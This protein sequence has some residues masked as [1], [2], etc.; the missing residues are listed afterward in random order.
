M[1]NLSSLFTALIGDSFWA[2]FLKV[3]IVPLGVSVV[4]GWA[5]ASV[6]EPRWVAPGW[7]YYHGYGKNVEVL[8]ILGGARR[9]YRDSPACPL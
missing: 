3:F 9:W 2:R 1:R 7:P 8:A 6:A 5:I 4:V